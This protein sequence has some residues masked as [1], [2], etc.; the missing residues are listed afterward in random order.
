MSAQRAGHGHD[1]RKDENLLQLIAH[2]ERELEAA[3][4]AARQEAAALVAR[5]RADAERILQQARDEIAAASRAH[6]ERVAA[7]TA[8]I[9]MDHETRAQQ[10]VDALRRQ[11]AARRAQAVRLVVDRVLRGAST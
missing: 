1:D 8:Q 10:E 11:A 2:K 4:A 7:T 9:A 5:A 3:L 6:E